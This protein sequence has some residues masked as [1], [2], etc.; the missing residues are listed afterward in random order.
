MKAAAPPSEVLGLY[1][2]P[3]ANAVYRI[4]TPM[5][6][7][8]GSWASISAV[9]REQL[10]AAQTVV[11]HGIGGRRFDVV[12][13]FKS[14]RSYGVKRILVDYDDAIFHPHPV[15]EVRITRTALAGVQEALRQADGVVVTNDY[16]R[17]HF[18]ARTAAPVSVVPN[19][20]LP[21]D[22][23]AQA[24]PSD[25]GPPVIVLAGS[26]SHRRDWD[27]VLPALL[28]MRQQIPDVQLR[29][30]GYGHPH[31]KQIATQGG[32]GWSSPPEYHRALVGGSI[33]L[34]PLLDTPFNHGKSPVKA[35]EY[36]LAAGMAVIGSTTQYSSLL[37]EGRGVTIDD[38]SHWG[39]HIAIGQ[40]LADPAA[41]R[42]VAQNLRDHI[43]SVYDARAWAD[44]IKTAYSV[45]DLECQPS[46]PA[47]MG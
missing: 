10:D 7:I 20:I 34:C 5:R 25:D 13:A 14:L 18:E 6:A 29:L 21:E 16:L 31:L 12:Q 36:S 35:F 37:G 11:I 32:G 1:V 8:G 30:L 17:E 42:G 43:L 15:K 27:L 39:W 26:P 33:G 28:Q 19:L 2:L 40:L 4:I 47:R 3:N 41:R 24:P 38:G 44:R 22:W 46:S 45:E 9:S 23:P